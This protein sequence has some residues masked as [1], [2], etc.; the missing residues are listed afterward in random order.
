MVTFRSRPGWLIP[1]ACIT[2]FHLATMFLRRTGIL[3]PAASV[4]SGVSSAARQPAYHP[5]AQSG[6]NNLDA[7]LRGPGVF[8]FIF[9]PSSRIP[10]EDGAYN[11]CNMPHVRR[12]TYVRPGDEYEL[13]FVEVAHRHHK[14]TPYRDN[15]FPVESYAWDCDDVGLYQFG[16]PLVEEGHGVAKV[17]QALFV[18]EVNPFLPVGWQGRCKFPQ[19]T[20]GGLD[21][22]W[23]HGADLYAV[24]GKLLGFLPGKD[25]DAWREKVKYRVT[26]NPITS[27]VAGM[28]INGMWG[29]TGSVPLL[30]EDDAVD[31]LEPRYGCPAGSNLYNG[32]RSKAPWRDH[33]TAAEPVFS[34]L[35]DLSGVPR[36]DDGFHISFDHYFDNLSSRQCHGKPL[37]CKLVNGVNSSNCV[38][39]DQADTVYRLGHWEYSQQYRDDPD[40]LAMAT[41]TIGVWFA[42]LLAHFRQAVAGRSDTIYFHNVAHDGSIS[43]MLA[44]LQIDTMFWPGLGAEI[45]FEIWKKKIRPLSGDGIDKDSSSSGYFLRVLYGGSVLTSSSPSLGTIEM[46]PLETFQEYVVGLV[47]KDASSIRDLCT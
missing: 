9:D 12:A 3:L 45:V 43:R 38:T 1:F 19:I 10:D 25:G 11:F 31:S 13:A 6:F 7:A 44:F 30:V 33:L 14:R 16:E 39:Q 8:G 24:Y 29:A 20:A 4:L 15:S 46:I 18:S 17:Y 34:A 21:D 40:S 36:N 32:V 27:Q 2:I 47:G 23:R 42:E 41:M 35:D 28:V 22:S 37:P 26:N 5:P